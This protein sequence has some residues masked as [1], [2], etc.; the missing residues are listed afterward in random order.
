MSSGIFRK[1]LVKGNEKNGKSNA[2]THGHGVVIV[3]SDSFANRITW[4]KAPSDPAAAE[5]ATMR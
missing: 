5:R 1:S 3:D 4:R 2:D